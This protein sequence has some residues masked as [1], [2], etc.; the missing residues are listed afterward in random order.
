MKRNKIFK[1]LSS[2][3]LAVILFVFFAVILAT[4]TFYESTYDTPTAQHLV[5]KSPLFAVFLAVFFVNI[6]CSTA[7]RYPWS[8]KQVGFV[9]THLGILILLAA[10]AFTMVSGVDGSMIVQEG[11]TSKRIMLKD[12]VFFVGRPSEPMK[13][14]PAE[15]RWTPPSE[16]KPQRVAL[17]EGVTAEVVQYLHHARRNT[18]YKEAPKGV[19][20]LEMRIF[21]ERVDQHQWLTAGKGDVQL[22]PARIRLL[23]ANDGS[24]TGLALSAIKTTRGI[25]SLKVRV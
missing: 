9:F 21:N 4:A 20:A 24:P 23:R 6:F 11:Q 14:V 1:F 22:G 16:S 12:P 25:V 15:F 5:Y 19:P 17:I 8:K 13:E 7:I 2:I 10:A 18:F 3:K